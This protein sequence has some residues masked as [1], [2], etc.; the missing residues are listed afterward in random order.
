MSLLPQTPTHPYLTCV[1]NSGNE[2]SLQAGLKY[3]SGGHQIR[4]GVSEERAGGAA[5]GPY[6]GLGAANT[7]ISNTTGF[8][9]NS[10]G[11]SGLSQQTKPGYQGGGEITLAGNAWAKSI[12]AFI[13]NT[14]DCSDIPEMFR[15]YATGTILGQSSDCVPLQPCPS[16][17]VVSVYVIVSFANYLSSLG[18]NTSVPGFTPPGGA[19]PCV[20]ASKGDMSQWQKDLQSWIKAHPGQPPP[21]DLVNPP[22]LAACGG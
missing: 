22:I 1:A 13:C 18:V 16:G 17:L 20:A 4:D 8:S 11:P 12:A 14:A 21:P 3:V 19:P 5:P 6:N 2:A 7:L 10:A 9:W 15:P